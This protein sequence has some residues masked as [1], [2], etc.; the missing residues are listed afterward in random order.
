MEFDTLIKKSI[1]ITLKLRTRNLLNT[2]TLQ[3]TYPLSIL[4]KFLN[5]KAEVFKLLVT[6]HFQIFSM[7]SF[8]S[9]Q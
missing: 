4:I 1:R 7:R 2:P 3:L 6:M 9:G 5:Q 8:H